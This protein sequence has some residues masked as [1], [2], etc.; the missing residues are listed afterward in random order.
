[1]RKLRINARFQGGWEKLL[2]SGI[3]WQPDPIGRGSDLKSAAASALV[4]SPGSSSFVFTSL[5]DLAAR[6]D[7][8]WSRRGAE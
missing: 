2:E 5:E 1:M 8:T 4:Y 7:D 6:I 3:N